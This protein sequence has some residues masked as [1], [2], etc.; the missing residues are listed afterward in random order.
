MILWYKPKKPGVVAS[1]FY[2]MYGAGRIFNENFRLPDAHLAN[3]AEQ[4]LG[5]SRGQFLSIFIIALGLMFLV[6]CLKR[7][8]NKLGG[9]GK[10]N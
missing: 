10:P 2:L 9:W 5:I 3:L 6:W 4:P 7:P 1:V 8:A